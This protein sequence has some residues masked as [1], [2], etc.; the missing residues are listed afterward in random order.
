MERVHGAVNK[1]V[2]V[3]ARA[4]STNRGNKSDWGARG[5]GTKRR[6]RWHA[7]DGRRWRDGWGKEIGVGVEHEST[8]GHVKRVRV[9]VGTKLRGRWH[10]HDGRCWRDGWGEEI[11]VGV[12]RYRGHVKRVGLRSGWVLVQS[13]EG[14]TPVMGAVCEMGGERR[15]GVGVER[16]SRG[17]ALFAK[18]VLRRWHACSW[19]C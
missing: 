3:G 18:R 9:G 15:L 12:N 6:G 10:A 17:G 4:L 11:G 7:R 19:R 14:G 13:E 16:E 1:W 2:G 8:G 5:V